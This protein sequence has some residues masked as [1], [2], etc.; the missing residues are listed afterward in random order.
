MSEAR[1]RVRSSSVKDLDMKVEVV[2]VSVSDV[3][4]AE[5]FYGRLGWRL[6]VTPPTVVQFTPHGSACS[7]QFGA[8][9]TSAAPGSA[10][11]YLIV[12]DLEA[13]RNALVA[14]GI[15][16]GEIFHISPDGPVSGPDPGAPGRWRF[17]TFELFLQGDRAGVVARTADLQ[18]R[19]AQ[20]GVP[21]QGGVQGANGILESLG[22]VPEGQRCK[23]AGDWLR[24]FF[25]LRQ[26]LLADGFLQFLQLLLQL[27]QLGLAALLLFR[28]VLQNRG[29]HDVAFAVEDS[30]QGGGEPV[31]F[32]LAHRVKL[33]VVAAGTMHRQPQ[34]GLAHR[35]HH[36]SSSSCRTTAFMAK[37]CCCWPTLSKPQATRNPVAM[38][39]CGSLG[40]RR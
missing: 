13:A 2:V 20:F 32:L 5:D 12:S 39:P 40:N 21:V 37:L 8:T 4:R 30:A 36:V 14:A 27:G 23:I 35:G 28:K 6:D 11:G 33:V 15:E 24:R 25:A 26:N 16:V 3:D 31:V 38:V 10:K 22:E 18:S 9:L 34:K 1:I 19:G 29:S 17:R 7:V